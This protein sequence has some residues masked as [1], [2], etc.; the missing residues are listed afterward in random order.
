[1]LLTPA[2]GS[3]SEIINISD[4]DSDDVKSQQEHLADQDIIV[5]SDNELE[6]QPERAIDHRRSSSHSLTDERLQQK[7]V[8][9]PFFPSSEDKQDSTSEDKERG[10]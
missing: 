9:P 5:I 10:C 6:S 1:M 4:S 2:A 3:K 8:E 7:T